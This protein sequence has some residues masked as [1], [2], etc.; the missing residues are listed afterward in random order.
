MALRNNILPPCVG[1]QQPE[2]NLNL[3]RSAQES[4]IKNVLCFS[5]GF[6]GQ[7]AIMALGNFKTR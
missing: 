5:F 7:N 2:F 3:I 6:G 1:L 4:K